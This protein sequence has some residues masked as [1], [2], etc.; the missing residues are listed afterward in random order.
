MAAKAKAAAQKAKSSNGWK[1][2]RRGHKYRGAGLVPSAGPV[3]SKPG[4]N[5][6]LAPY[7]ARFSNNR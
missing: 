3:A 6:R 4:N 2:C 1:T 7:L 5:P